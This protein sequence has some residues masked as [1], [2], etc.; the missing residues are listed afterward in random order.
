MLKAATKFIPEVADEEP[1]VSNPVFH[2]QIHGPVL[3]K[4]MSISAMSGFRHMS[5]E[6]LRVADWILDRR[7][8]I[9]EDLG[10]GR[11]KAL[12]LGRAWEKEGPLPIPSSSATASNK[13]RDPVAPATLGKRSF[14]PF[15]AK[16][17]EPG[18]SDIAGN[19]NGNIPRK[20]KDTK[21]ASSHFPPPGFGSRPNDLPLTASSA[22]N[23]L[24]TPM[25]R[26]EVDKSSQVNSTMVPSVPIPAPTA[27]SALQADNAP[28]G[29]GLRN[30]DHTPHVTFP[31]SPAAE[32]SLTV[33]NAEREWADALRRAHET[34]AQLARAQAAYGQAVVME[35][36]TFMEYCEARKSFDE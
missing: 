36:V 12:S 27:N 18:I 35:K 33:G 25:L 11:F 30:Q 9:E 21:P 23:A 20:P 13:P 32:R 16:G 10:T 26:A 28:K 31:L 29:F 2:Q 24:V 1:L 14:S 15:A 8:S 17:C 22:S 3:E 4:M 5:H 7:I 34:K 6:E 19:S